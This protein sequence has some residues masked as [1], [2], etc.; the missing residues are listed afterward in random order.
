MPEAQAIAPDNKDTSTESFANR[1]AA[2]V[3]AAAR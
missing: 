2:S 1:P 3:R